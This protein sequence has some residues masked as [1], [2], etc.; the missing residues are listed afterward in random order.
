[1]FVCLIPYPDVS[2]RRAMPGGPVY[3]AM[4]T[5]KK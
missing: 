1:L 4:I 2:S 3:V 5:H